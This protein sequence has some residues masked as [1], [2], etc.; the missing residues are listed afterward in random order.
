MF[1]IKVKLTA[2]LLEL[3]AVY[4]VLLGSLGS[5]RISSVWKRDNPWTVGDI[6]ADFYIWMLKTVTQHT[7]FLLIAFSLST[8]IINWTLLSHRLFLEVTWYS[9]MIYRKLFN[10][11]IVSS[12]PKLFS[13]QCAFIEYISYYCLS[14]DTRWSKENVKRANFSSIKISVIELIHHI[15]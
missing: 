11:S 12:G 6:L 9:L 2:V 13:L 4:V 10:A 14:L 1:W 7:N 5:V 3:E 15:W 8:C